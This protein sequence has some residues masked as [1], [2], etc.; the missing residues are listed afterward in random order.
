MYVALGDSVAAGDG[1]ATN[2][3]PSACNRT[4]ESYP[5][6]VARSAQQDLR[7]IACSGATTGAGILGVQ[8]VN[9]LTVDA[10][11]DQLFASKNPA[12]I[13]MTIG[14][15]DMQW[16]TL[17]TR[18]YNSLCGTPADT[19]LVDEHLLTLNTNL[20]RIL[21]SLQDHYTTNKPKIIVTGYYQIFAAKKQSCSEQSTIDQSEIDWERA[22]QTKLN[23]TIQNAVAAYPLAKFAP[24]DYTGHE[25]CT[26]DSWVQDLSAKAPFHPTAAGQ[27]A[28]V[29]AIQ[30]VK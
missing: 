23:T 29:K 15:N 3:D 24:V 8:D 2:S 27:Q 7:N 9:Q 5:S 10:Q 13:T 28:Y 25:L 21:Q 26:A 17:L 22:Q 20:R 4:D 30:A 14:A 18:C 1:L 11:L 6:V 19:A 12:V 16:T